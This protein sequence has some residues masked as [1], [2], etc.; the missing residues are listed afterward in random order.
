[1]NNA[2]KSNFLKIQGNLD[3]EQLKENKKNFLEK[4]LRPQ[5]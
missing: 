1:L 4:F 2:G 5:K 3:L